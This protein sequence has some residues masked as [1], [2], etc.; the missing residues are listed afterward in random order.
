MLHSYV[1]LSDNR[2]L[3]KDTGKMTVFNCPI[4]AEAVDTYLGREVPDFEQLGLEPDKQY[5]VYRPFAEIEKAA[6][7]FAGAEL[8]RGHITDPTDIE[9]NAKRLVGSVVGD[10]EARDG[11]LFSTLKINDPEAVGLIVD[12][13]CKELSCGYY[14]VPV[15]EA[16]VFNGRAY[17]IKMT[18]IKPDHVALVPEG[19][20]DGA[21]VVDSDL[22]DNHKKRGVLMSLLG[23]LKDALGIEERKLTG[24]T[25][26]GRE[27]F[28]K[29][30]ETAKNELGIDEADRPDDKIIG[31]EFL[32]GDDEAAEIA[33]MIYAWTDT[34][35]DRKNAARI[36]AF[37]DN[38]L[39][40]IERAEEGD[41]EVEI[42]EDEKRLIG[43]S[44]RRKHR[45]LALDAEAIAARVEAKVWQ[46]VKSRNE[47]AEACRYILSGVDTAQYSAHEIYK[48]A[49]DAKGLDPNAFSPASYRDV[50]LAMNQ[51]AKRNITLDWEIDKGSGAGKTSAHPGLSKFKPEHK[52]R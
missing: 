5:G 20:V 15:L 44:K 29:R 34:L 48:M 36:R 16:G 37:L 21:L 22:T 10:L 31:A 33:Q 47:A 52:I 26:A 14:Y 23:E 30:E 7:F 46:D 25:E 45:M 50:V 42:Q 27:A 1:F 32:V 12:E 38:V 8:Y 41:E 2:L 17:Q 11:K 6:P 4:T 51:D 3:D 49:L 9:N 28:E 18:D 40:P 19:R 13:I 24:G 39:R 43:D 35:E